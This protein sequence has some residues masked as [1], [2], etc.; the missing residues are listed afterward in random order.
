VKEMK[1]KE[2]YLSDKVVGG[3]SMP[4]TRVCPPYEMTVALAEN[5]VMNGLHLSLETA[6]L[7]MKLSDRRITEVITNRG[8]IYPKIVINAA[9]LFADEIAAMAKDQFFTIHPRKGE[10]ALLDKNKG[11]QLDTVVSV[12]SAKLINSDTKG[13]GLVKTVEGNILVGPNAF[14]QPYKEDYSTDSKTVDAMLNQ[15]FAYVKG[16]GKGD[17]I[18]YLAGTRAATYKEDFIIEKSKQ[19]DNLVY[20]AGIQS[21]GF[22]SSPAIAEEIEKITIGLLKEKHD[23]RLKQNFIRKRKG[24]PDLKNMP[25]DERSRLIEERKAYGQII[26]RCEE[27]SRGEIQDAIHS[28]IPATTLD[29]IKR[30]TR[31]GMGRCQGGFCTPLIAQILEEETGMSLLEM[32]KKGKDSNLVSKVTK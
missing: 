31:A 27:V 14:E 20:A 22:A 19:V 18:T 30:R 2:P 1:E 8:S 7:D 5:A 11:K 16:I 15:N 10:I 28:V 29:A 25:A 21:P 23:V 13:G 24:I 9:G 4:T 26:C 12:V 6:V 17:V 3:I 32:T